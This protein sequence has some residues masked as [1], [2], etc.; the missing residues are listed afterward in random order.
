MRYFDSCTLLA[1]TRLLVEMLGALVESKRRDSRIHEMKS[2]RSVWIEEAGETRG[3]RVG[4]ILRVQ[5][6]RDGRQQKPPI[7]TYIPYFHPPLG[8]HNAAI[9]NTTPSREEATWHIV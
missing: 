5:N 6:L 4:R 8:C 2:V 7:I 3:R 1:L 9:V